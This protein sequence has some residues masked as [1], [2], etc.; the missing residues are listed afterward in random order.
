MKRNLLIIFIF[1]LF[2]QKSVYADDRLSIQLDKCIDGDTAAFILNDER[3][4]VR[5]LAVDTPESVHPTKGSTSN[6]M[7]ASS[8]T[9]NKLENAKDIKLEYDPKS[10]K[11]DKYQR[12]L[13]WIWV[14]NVLLQKDLVESGYAEVKY[15][16]GDYLYLD[17][18]Y[19]VLDEAKINKRGIWEEKNFYYIS[20]IENENK[21]NK[22]LVT[23][24]ESIDEY[25]P[26]KDGYEFLGWY[27]GSEKYDFNNKINK[28]LE[29]TAKF[30]KESFIKEYMVIVI[31]LIAGYYLKD[32][33]LKKLAKKKLK[34]IT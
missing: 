24:D 11:L 29:L 25:I 26:V 20:F 33:S 19:K 7:I 8:Y 5:F 32:N 4:K 18:L 23:E 15:I 2:S 28:D 22:V 3:I 31:L 14:D 6:G 21:I 10:N 34:K 9:C 1:I 12:T 17:E 27:K 13:G 30:K 16:Y